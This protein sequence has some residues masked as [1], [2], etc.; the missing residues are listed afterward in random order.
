MTAFFLAVPAAV[1]FLLAV[2]AVIGCFLA[3]IRILGVFRFRRRRALTAGNDH[4]HG[5]ELADHDHRD[6]AR[7]LHFS[8]PGLRRWRGGFGG[9]SIWCSCRFGHDEYLPVSLL[10]A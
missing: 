5:N 6:D 7:D 2:A 1:T 8:Q 3:V 10:I 4:E 9:R